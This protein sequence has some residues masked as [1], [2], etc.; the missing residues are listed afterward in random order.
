MAKTT[1]ISYVEHTHNPWW[2]CSSPAGAGCDH[3][4]AAVLDHRTGGNHFGKGTV[5]RLTKQTNRS[6]PFRWNRQATTEGRR[7]RVLVGSMMDWGD[8][9]A[10][11]GAREELFAT[12]RATPMLD[13]LILTK[14]SSRINRLL[15]GDW[16]DGYPNVFL[17]TTVENR[18]Q[19]L[20]RLEQL[21]RVP[22]V[23]R[24]LSIEPLLEDLGDIDLTG[25]ATVVV[26]GE[27]GNGFR[28]MDLAWARNILAQCREQGVSFWFKQTGGRDGGT[29][30]LDGSRYQ[31]WQEVTPV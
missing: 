2:G 23:H 15:P 21:R 10:P 14:R 6:E 29:D 12:I 16:G 9:H 17:G 7:H 27:S 5:P 28:P 19:G 18:R 13:Y 31:E 1:N 20:R 30:F 25:I 26:G 4:F 11:D 24:W 8:R 22:A 3:C